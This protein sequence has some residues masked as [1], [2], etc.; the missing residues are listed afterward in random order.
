MGVG[1]FNLRVPVA[2]AGLREFSTRQSKLLRSTG[3]AI[4]IGRDHHVSVTRAITDSLL[5][6]I[7]L[8]TKQ[9]HMSSIARI[10]TRL[11]TLSRTLSLGIVIADHQ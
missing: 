11:M 2:P 6:T 1:R 9:Y 10:T 4:W 3:P 5:T 7:L 8:A